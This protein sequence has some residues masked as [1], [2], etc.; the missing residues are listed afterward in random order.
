MNRKNKRLRKKEEPLSSIIKTRETK[1]KKKGRNS[2]EGT[3]RI[4]ESMKRRM[5]KS[6]AHYKTGVKVTKENW[7]ED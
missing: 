2:K 1:L 7:K 6:V 3:T 5:N 4:E